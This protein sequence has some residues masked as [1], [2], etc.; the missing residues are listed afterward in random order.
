MHEKRESQMGLNS[1]W[2]V[3]AVFLSAEFCPF[4]F[5]QLRMSSSCHESDFRISMMLTK[6]RRHVHRS[7]S[8]IWR[9]KIKFDNE[10]LIIKANAMQ[11]QG[12]Y[13]MDARKTMSS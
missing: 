6:C 4:F 2:E 12:H 11:F 7:G 5:V 13:K 10:P 8:G 1:G 3:T 9:Q